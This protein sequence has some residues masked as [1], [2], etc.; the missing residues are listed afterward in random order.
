MGERGGRG[1]NIMHA[2]IMQWKSTY[3]EALISTE[4]GFSPLTPLSHGELEEDSSTTFCS[5]VPGVQ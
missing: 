3:L 4:D 5:L 1:G 2:P